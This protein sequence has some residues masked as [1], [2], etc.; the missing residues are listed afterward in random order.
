MRDLTA[1]CFPVTLQ[2]NRTFFLNLHLKSSSLW[3]RG[4]NKL[5]MEAFMVHYKLNVSIWK[6]EIAHFDA[7]LLL[8]SPY[9]CVNFL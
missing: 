2:S 7:N 4:W 3:D 5:Q 1:K 8:L 6:N 9:F